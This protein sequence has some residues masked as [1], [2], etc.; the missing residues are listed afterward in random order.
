[1]NKEK[2][3]SL[4][5]EDL[6]DGSVAAGVAKLVMQAR[7]SGMWVRVFDIRYCTAGIP[8][9]I[10]NDYILF[11]PGAVEVLETGNLNEPAHSIE[12]LFHSRA[13]ACQGVIQFEICKPSV[14]KRK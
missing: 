2:E 3:A 1:M 6:R 12:E 13:V 9:E 5:A 8:V 10:T 4:S 14:I 11:G 7:M